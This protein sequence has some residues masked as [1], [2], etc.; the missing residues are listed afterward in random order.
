MRRRRSLIRR[1]PGASPTA[2]GS[3]RGAGR[4]RRRR[5][6][7]SPR[8]GPR[9]RSCR[10][11]SARRTATGRGWRRSP[12]AC[13]LARAEARTPA[14]RRRPAAATATATA[15]DVRRDDGGG[16]GGGSPETTVGVPSGAVVSAARARRADHLARTRRPLRGLLGQ[17]APQH[18]VQLGRQPR[19]ASVVDGGGSKRCAH[20]VATSVSRRNGARPVSASKSTQP[21]EYTSERRRRLGP[22]EQLGRDVVH[23]ADPVAGRGARVASAEVL[24]R[25]EVGQPG[26]LVLEQDVRGL[27]VAVHDAARVGSVERGGDL[28]RAG[29]ARPAARARPSRAGARRGRRRRPSA[30]SGTAA[31]R[32]RRPRRSGSRSGVRARPAAATR[33]RSATRTRSRR[34]RRRD[35][36]QRHGAPEP[37]CASPGRR[38]P[39]RRARLRLRSGGRRTRRPSRSSELTDADRPGLERDFDELR[40]LRVVRQ[41]A[42]AEA[43]EEVAQ[44]GLHAR[45]AQRDLVGDLPGWRPAW[46][47]GCPPCRDGTGR[48]ARRAASAQRLGRGRAGRRARARSAVTLAGRVVERAAWRRRGPCRRR[49]A[50]F[51]PCRRSPLRNVPL[52]RQPMVGEHPMRADALELGVQ[53]RDLLVVREHEVAPASRRSSPPSERRIRWPSSAPARNGSPARSAS[54]RL[55]LGRRGTCI[56]AAIPGSRRSIPGCGRRALRA[57]EERAPATGQ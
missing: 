30:C 19:R 10:A 24:A 31:R 5:T 48:S 9:S 15:A 35:Q 32:P 55:Q 16:A 40:P 46:R 45:H 21:N 13:C 47:T 33:A 34:Q 17:R 43:L 56:V 12:P 22:V 14:P 36:L 52:R 1:R 18:V 29:S 23:R 6:P 25:A 42:D 26:V 2:P 11:G 3:L 39:C 49:A 7:W 57:S 51:S 44:V 50:R 37:A 28:A 54:S 41:L 53:A 4:R 8:P 20:S 38:P 27:D